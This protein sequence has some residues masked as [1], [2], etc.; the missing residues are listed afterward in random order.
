MMVRHTVLKKI[1]F[2]RSRLSYTLDGTSL[3]YTLHPKSNAIPIQ[4][5]SWQSPMVGHKAK[6]GKVGC[7]LNSNS[8]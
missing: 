6:L 7:I 4:K 2:S 5:P 8:N 3:N 1:V